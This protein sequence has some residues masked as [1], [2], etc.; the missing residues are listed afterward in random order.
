ITFRH[1]PASSHLILAQKLCAWTARI[2]CLATKRD[3]RSACEASPVALN[4]RFRR[5]ISMAKP[6]RGK[7]KRTLWVRSLCTDTSSSYS[8]GQEARR[9]FEQD[10]RGDEE[11]GAD[12]VS[13]D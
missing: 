12:V 13:A 3:N 5:S 6:V 9:N 4:H 7:V 8:D 1:K 2:P 10:C 11:G